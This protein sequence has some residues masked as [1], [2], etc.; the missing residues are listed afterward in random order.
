MLAILIWGYIN[1]VVY[2]ATICGI[3]FIITAFYL[4]GMLDTNDMKKYDQVV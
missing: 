4:K 2:L 1:M 3:C